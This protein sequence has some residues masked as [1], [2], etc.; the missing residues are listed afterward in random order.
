MK[1]IDIDFIRAR[2]LPLVALVLLFAGLVILAD[3]VAD[4]RAL[5]ATH[6]ASLARIEALEGQLARRT[7]LRAQQEAQPDPR[8]ERQQAQDKKVL[9][10][11]AYPWPRVLA[12]VEQP[13][14]QGVA[15][16]SFSHDADTSRVRLTVEGGDLPAIGRYVEQL[17]QASR[18]RMPWQWYV[19]S[20][21]QTQNTP[22]TVK[23]TILTR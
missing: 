21:Q 8:T 6:E 16:L 1:R 12:I 10:A 2:R 19:A 5:T 22:A 18:E 15:L 14:M 3:R 4:W 13:D 20:Y 9:A 7:R 23:A 17:N 11:L